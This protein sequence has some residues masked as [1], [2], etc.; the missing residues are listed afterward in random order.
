MKVKIY[1]ILVLL[2]NSLFAQKVSSSIDSVAKKIGSEF[3]LTLKTEVGKNDKVVFPKGN[4]FG[5][6][7]VLEIYKTDTIEKGNTLELIKKYG[8]TQ[9]DKGTY[10]VPKLPV[11]INGTPFFSDS[12]K[13]EI[14]EV[15]V[16]TLK[17]KMY[18][19]KDITT[20]ESS[21]IWW[22]VLLFFIA[23]ALIGY[24]IYYF[25]KKHQ[26]KEKPEE[27]IYKTPIEKAT[28]LLQILET[29]QLL[30]KGEIKNYYS[31]LTDITRTY[32]EE[33]INIPAMES[34]TSELIENLRKTAKQKKLKLSAETVSNLERVLKQAD[35][36]KFAKVK[37]LDFEIEEDK[38][39][40]SS[41]I[42]T[43]HKSIPVEVTT[44]EDEAWNE[45]QRE[46]LK[47]AKLRKQKTKRILITVASVVL[48]FCLSIASLIY[49]KGMDYVRDN[50]IGH[51][52]KDLVETQWIYS[53][54]G[55]PGIKIETP[56]VL[57][58]IN[59]GNAIPKQVQQGIKSNQSFAYGS[60][61][62]N[63]FIMLSTT[64]FKQEVASNLDLAIEGSIKMLEAQGATN[65]LV[66]SE[67]FDTQQ[68]IS[69]RK[70][71]GTFTPANKNSSE[72]MYY[73]LLV[74]GQNGGL[75]QI[76]IMHKDSDVYGQQIAERVLNSVELKQAEK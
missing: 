49:F 70:A 72:R 25:V 63:F 30:Q 15:K 12:I 5:A 40:I 17:Q 10:F 4:Q 69:G 8:V 52:T 18:D 62:D 37:P 41:S 3:K 51:P 31:E 55:N 66:K 21:S 58:R 11:I 26:A 54:Y 73:E 42:I 9:F 20:V 19:I 74:F 53:E 32:I 57:K 68:G 28:S 56:K 38:K 36:V 60:F 61:Q 35:L 39:R 67:E 64:S 23:L 27:V 29:K 50:F 33:E 24:I 7:E 43:I 2:S 75:Q 47:Q 45:Q 22:K 59:L 14:Q 76:V 1:I 48:L 71:F 6:L 34:T 65:M 46:L 44:S 13:I 16:D